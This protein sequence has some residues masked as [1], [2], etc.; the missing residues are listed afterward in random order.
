MS[1]D[2][3]CGDDGIWRCQHGTV[4]AALCRECDPHPD[5]ELLAA[6]AA[7]QRLEKWL[8]AN[9]GKCAYVLKWQTEELYTMAINTTRLDD[10]PSLAEAINA[11]LDEAER[12]GL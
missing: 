7:L 8:D 6:A 5:Q 4:L 2:A 11:A 10:K 9:R 12:R 3:K 1:T